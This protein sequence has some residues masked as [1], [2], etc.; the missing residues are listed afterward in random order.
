MEE[1]QI[2]SHIFY[3]YDPVR[4]QIDLYSF[5][6]CRDILESVHRGKHS[7]F[8]GDRCFNATVYFKDS[9]FGPMYQTTPII[10]G[11]KPAGHRYVFA[12]TLDGTISEIIL[13]T[14]K[15]NGEWYMKHRQPSRLDCIELDTDTR[16]TKITKIIPD[17]YYS[18]NEAAA[19]TLPVWQWCFKVPE[20]CH[21]STI[22]HSAEEDWKEYPRDINSS[23]EELYQD[24]AK[25]EISIEVGIRK[26]MIT[27]PPNSIFGKQY[28]PIYKK[29]RIIRRKMIH[30]IKAEGIWNAM[31]AETDETCAIC[32]DP[33]RETDQ[34]IR[35]PCGHRFHGCCI[36]H[37]ADV[38]DRCAYCRTE[39]NWEDVMRDHGCRVGQVYNEGGR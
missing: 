37:L 29:T 23:I 33:M 2:L 5:D 16:L 19:D 20:T 35:I 12:Q 9:I 36:Q 1:G 10:P 34:L 14:S 13:Y 7:L 39:V 38:G 28:D 4:N 15:S 25:T 24:N 22:Y 26:F 31:G 6:I 18:K 17:H 30:D 21:Y 8:L 11:R 27:I 32:L 3:S